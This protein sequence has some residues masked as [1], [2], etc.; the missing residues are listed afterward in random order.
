MNSVQ[1]NMQLYN[2]E[3]DN[4]CQRI[5]YGVVRLPQGEQL[6]VSGYLDWCLWSPVRRVDDDEDSLT[7]DLMTTTRLP[8]CCVVVMSPSSNACMGRQV[9][10][11]NEEFHQ[12]HVVLKY[13][14]WCQCCHQNDTD[15]PLP[16]LGMIDVNVQPSPA[17]YHNVDRLGT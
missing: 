12:I 6:G 4:K 3:Q 14:L 7:C 10:W 8:C 13:N 16:T 11:R 5:N 1:Y 2:D 9:C 17:H 15:I